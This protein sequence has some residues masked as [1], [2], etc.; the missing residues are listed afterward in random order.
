MCWISLFLL[1][2]ASGISGSQ[3]L[4]T[5]QCSNGFTSLSSGCYAFVGEKR[6]Y[7]AAQAYCASLS[8]RA[9]LVEFET[10]GETNAVTA[11]LQEQQEI[12]CYGQ[13]H[14]A[15]KTWDFFHVC[16]E[17][18]NTGPPRTT[19]LPPPGQ[20]PQG[21]T[22]LSTG[23]YAFVG[24]KRTYDAAQAYCASLAHGAR[25]V[26]FETESENDAVTAYLQHQQLIRCYA[27]WIGAEETGTQGV[28]KWASTGAPLSFYR[29]LS[30]QPDNT[31]PGGDGIL[32]SCDDAWQWHDV[33]KT[34]DFFHICE[35]ARRSVSSSTA[36][37]TTSK[38]HH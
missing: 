19:T 17:E 13:W 22:E 5:G 3:S 16:E 8:D 6:T 1:T 27:W 34:W 18:T 20:C 9:R 36:P 32:M 10:E 37:S 28:Y 31:S 35:K 11:Y 15:P 29:W 24:E 2:V 14:D 12:R 21:F 7:D 30:G 25:L 23:C 4:W 26:E 38:D 33:P